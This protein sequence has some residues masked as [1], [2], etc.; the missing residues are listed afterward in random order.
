MK[1]SEFITVDVPITKE[2]V[3]A[4]ALSKLDIL[5]AEKF[6]DIGSGT[7]SVSV[8]A[9]VMNENLK[10]YS[11][12]DDPR[13]EKLLKKNIEKFKLNNICFF[14]G[15]APLDNFDTTK[16][17][18]INE[19]V[20]INK[21]V[22]VDTNKQAKTDDYAYTS[23]EVDANIDKSTNKIDNDQK[24]SFDAVF[25]GGTGG[26]LKEI[27]SWTRTILKPGGR[28]VA[29]F[30]IND[31]FNQAYN[32]FKEVGFSEVEVLQLSVNVL[33]TL[34]K[35]EYFKPQNPIFIISARK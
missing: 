1:N 11:I 25:I 2:E 27:I 21:Q 6:L 5:R 33:S 18:E 28:V 12:D 10:V 22:K 3:R 9:A 20:D 7:G 14:K 26:N 23:K 35:G 16:E 34:G 8:E 17:V 30:I 24:D 31:T 19:N 13:A 4:I 15:K 29:N 32:F